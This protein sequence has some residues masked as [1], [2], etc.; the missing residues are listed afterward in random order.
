MADAGENHREPGL[1][2]APSIL[3]ADI[4]AHFGFYENTRIHKLDKTNAVCKIC[5]T[6]IKYVGNTTNLRNHV[7]RFHSKKLT[8]STIKET[9]DPAQP[10]ID[11]KLSVLPPNA[12]KAKRII[13]SVVAFI[14]ADLQPYSVV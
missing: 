6:K 12:E 3:K 2:I 8:P 5:H 9:V 11:E 10:R 7:S 14:A 4:W 1:K 13:Q